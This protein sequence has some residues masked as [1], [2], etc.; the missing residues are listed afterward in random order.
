MS[1]QKIIS[2]LIIL[3]LGVGGVILYQSLR[4]GNAKN[5]IAQ[6]KCDQ[7][8]T[9]QDCKSISLATSTWKVFENTKY[10]YAISYPS[11]GDIAT[12]G[13]YG[14]VEEMSFGIPGKTD[15]G[16]VKTTVYP[17][18]PSDLK[19]YAEA[20]RVLQINNR[21]PVYFENQK[22]EEMKQIEITF[23]KAYKFT[24]A[25]VDATISLQFPPFDRTK[26]LDIKSYGEALRMFNVGE[27]LKR[28]K[29]QKIGE[30]KETV[31]DG[32]KAY[33]F[34]LDKTFVTI[35][36]GYVIPDGQ[37]YLYT[38][39]ENLKGQKIIIYYFLGN[40][41]AETMYRTFVFK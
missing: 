17:N 24:P 13:D 41:I 30:L 12:G 15:L 38:I 11:E 18:L 32:R 31:I 40:P 8:T 23:R 39:T 14:R 21:D 26:G 28:L 36:G 20:I 3:F 37:T 16:G 6:G 35:H 27:S 10:G 19:L 25:P 33:Q 4:A 7:F 29:D 9:T 34:T 2:L 1:K 5:P 22:T